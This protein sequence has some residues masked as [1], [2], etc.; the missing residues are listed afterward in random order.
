MTGSG[1]DLLFDLW[2]TEFQQGHPDMAEDRHRF[3]ADSAFQYALR[4]ARGM[5]VSR[6]A[7]V[8]SEAAGDEIAAIAKELPE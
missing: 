2:F 4:S 3:L 5:V 1:W 8:T 7:L 6:M